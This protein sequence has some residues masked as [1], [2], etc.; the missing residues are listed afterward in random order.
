LRSALHKRGLRFRVHRTVPGT[1][2]TIDVAFPKARVAV[3]LD[4]CFWH[5][6]PLHQTFP[7]R[8]ASWWREKIAANQDRDADTGRRLSANG[9]E[10]LRFWEH[11]DTEIVA[12]IITTTV[13]HRLDQLSGRTNTTSR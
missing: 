9:W 10:V 4:G 6:C 3:F 2:R 1:R 5:G 8:N 13:R 11:E 12:A 7:K